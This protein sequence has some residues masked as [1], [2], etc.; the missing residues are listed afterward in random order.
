MGGDVDVEGDAEGDAVVAN[1]LRPS[2]DLR[3]LEATLKSPLTLIFRTL[4]CAQVLRR[5]PT[6]TGLLAS[7]L[8]VGNP[9][10]GPIRLERVCT[11]L[12]IVQDHKKVYYS[13]LLLHGSAAR[14]R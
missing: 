5:D 1:L 12:H 6:P 11:S 4:R 9:L 14:A 3:D 13:T 2:Q 8:H 7:L 10:G